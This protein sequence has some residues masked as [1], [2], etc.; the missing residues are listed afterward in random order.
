MALF[1]SSS[2]S[3]E[4]TASACEAR[5]STPREEERDATE[6]T[7]SNRVSHFWMELKC[8]QHL[9]FLR[10]IKCPRAAAVKSIPLHFQLFSC[11][12]EHP[13]YGSS[14]HEERGREG[15]YRANG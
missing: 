2:F 4:D 10:C 15:A 14:K 11:L 13:V 7:I 9:A 5:I 6:D 3:V 1:F 12:R 8:V